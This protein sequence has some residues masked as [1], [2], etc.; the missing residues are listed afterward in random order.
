MLK[1]EEVLRLRSV[2]KIN[3]NMEEKKKGGEEGEEGEKGEKGREGR[4]GEEQQQEED[5][6][7]KTSVFLSS[8]PL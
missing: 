4:E 2:K 3:N 5:L 7:K 6:K 8:S 1:S